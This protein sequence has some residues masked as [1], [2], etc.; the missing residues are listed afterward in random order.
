MSEAFAKIDIRFT[1]PVTI[2][3]GTLTDLKKAEA[4]K[5]AKKKKRKAAAKKTTTTEES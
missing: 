3:Q 4:E 1:K 5:A 2:K